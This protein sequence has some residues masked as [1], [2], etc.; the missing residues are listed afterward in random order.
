MF[1]GKHGQARRNQIEQGAFLDHAVQRAVGLAAD[2]PALWIRRV[3]VDA[4]RGEPGAVQRPEVDGNVLHE[5][6]VFGADGIKLRTGG[7][8]F[9]LH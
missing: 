9:F 2:D 4:Q 6:G 1:A 8:T 3:S 5:D 7:E